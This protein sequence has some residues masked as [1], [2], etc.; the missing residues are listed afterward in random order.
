MKVEKTNGEA[1]PALTAKK[2]KAPDE[3]KSVLP[4]GINPENAEKPPPTDAPSERSPVRAWSGPFEEL[5]GSARPH[6][7]PGAYSNKSLR[8]Q[9]RRLQGQLPQDQGQPGPGWRTRQ[10]LLST[11]NRGTR[12]LALCPG[13]ITQAQF[14]SLIMIEVAPIGKEVGMRTKLPTETA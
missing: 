8:R 6:R 1:E 4:S 2:R 10:L 13:T 14:P 9:A 5:R 12:S 3:A 7:R 11:L